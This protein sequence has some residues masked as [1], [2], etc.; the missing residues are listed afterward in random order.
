MVRAEALLPPLRC[1]EVTFPQATLGITVDNATGE[2][3][4]RV[5]VT[6]VDAMARDLGFELMYSVLGINGVTC[7]ELGLHSHQ[8]L[9]VYLEAIPTRPLR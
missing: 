9:A 8:A 6:K 7:M 3:D 4:D 5:V 1:I 2:E